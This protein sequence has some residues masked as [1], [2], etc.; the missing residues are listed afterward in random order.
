MKYKIE[1][2][3]LLIDAYKMHKT[4]GCSSTSQLELIDILTKVWNNQRF[5]T[6]QDIKTLIDLG[7]KGT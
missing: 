7:L 4:Y 6:K 3:L 1:T 2:G 5:L